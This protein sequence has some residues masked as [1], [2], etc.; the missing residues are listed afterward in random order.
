MNVRSFKLFFLNFYR[1]R[2]SNGVAGQSE[3]AIPAHVDDGARLRSHRR[4]DSLFGGL[5]VFES[6]GQKDGAN[7][8]VVQ[9]T[10]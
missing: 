3:G 2:W 10:A 8:Q 7:V 1:I 6:V 4:G 5:R 9:R